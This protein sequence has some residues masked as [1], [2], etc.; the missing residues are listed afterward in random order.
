MTIFEAFFRPQGVAIVGASRDPF[1]LGY[2]VVRN[3]V[4][5]HYDGGI[6]PINPRADEILGHKCYNTVF[7][8]PD[9]VD[10]AVLVV[11]APA[12]EEELL[13]CVERG[14]SHV[15]VVS[16][17]FREVGPE[18]V[19]R[20]E[21]LKQICA[22]HDI[23]LLGPN[24]I[25]TIDTHT[26]FNSTFVA[27]HPRPGDIGFI[28]QSGAVTAAVIDWARGSGV[29]F[30][31]MV[32]LGNQ[33]GVNDVDMLNTLANDHNT[34]VITT[35]I[36]GVSDGQAFLHSASRIS[37]QRPIIA[38]KVGRSSAGAKAVTSHTGALAGTEAAYNAAFRRA[39]VLRASRLE[40]MLDWALAIAWQPLPRGNC[41]GVL[42]NAGGAGVMAVD[43][44]EAAGMELAPLT[45]ATKNY[46]SQR[47]PP[48]ASIQNPI[49]ILAG[50]GPASY[51]L[52]LDGLLSDETVD[53][54]VVITAPQ[55]WFAPVSLAEVI[56]EVSSSPLGRKKPVLAVIMG[57]ASTSD[58]TQ[59]LH[60]RRVP[61]FAFPERIGST[62]A[63]MWQ[64]K[65]W[66]DSNSDTTDIG[67]LP[68]PDDLKFSPGWLPQ[69]GVDALLA[70]YQIP[71][72]PSAVLD[73]PDEA[74]NFADSLGYP[75]V[76]KLLA[77]DV[78][79]KTDIG[80]VRLNLL[81]WNAVY[82]VAEGL[83]NTPFTGAKHLLVQKMIT[84][85]V[86]AIVG[87]VRDSQFGPLM[88]VG[89]G[90]TQVELIKDAAFEL[91]PVT[92]KLAG[93]MIDRTTLSLL[94]QGYRGRPAADRESLVKIIERLSH[95]AVNH[96]EIAEIEINPLIVRD[97]GA[98]AVDMR[99]RVEK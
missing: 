90:G 26:P 47:L 86:E 55:D 4:N 98:Y 28:S 69:E 49:D 73:T 53:A 11:P 96:P 87:M 5:H 33:S 8:V 95:I 88:M 75:V 25:G 16:G 20:E 93:E 54:V 58:A 57:L 39:G 9:P 10:L 79:H 65:Q 3:L 24:C 43:A 56:G 52:C 89:S 78:T 72:P 2:G 59:V 32:S 68:P 92:R 27:G 34:H 1:K 41:V 63:A 18:G 15:T 35:Y 62:L 45:D 36:E 67:I 94:L 19:V 64:R 82:Q 99:V 31:R 30:S 91:A 60:R 13:R 22:E 48:M 21:R 81:D 71:C 50:S 83:L 74:A 66:L 38:L 23:A 97:D 61:N 77:G 46:L 44:L 76:L 42:T 40:E 80:G 84:G 70:A 29:G 37:K 17:G 6:Y 85:G 7:D 14:I 51:A 12:V